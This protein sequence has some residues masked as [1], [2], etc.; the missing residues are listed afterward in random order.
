[1]KT[2]GEVEGVKGNIKMFVG[3]QKEKKRFLIFL[4]VEPLDTLIQ[5]FLEMV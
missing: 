5:N 4:A 3:K 1:M 2:R